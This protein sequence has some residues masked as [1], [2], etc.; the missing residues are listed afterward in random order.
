MNLQN[1]KCRQLNSFKNLTLI[2]I[3]LFVALLIT[4]SFCNL[5]ERSKAKRLIVITVASDVNNEGF[6]RFNRSIQHFGHELVVLGSNEEWRGGDLRTNSGGGQK[7]NYFY[8]ALAT[9]K[10]ES[11]LAILF[12]DSYDL[13]INANSSKI[14]ETYESKFV[15]AN[16][17]FSAEAT[18]WPD[19]NLARQFPI[20]LLGGKKYLNSGAIIGFAPSLWQLV[21]IVIDQNKKG[22]SGSGVPDKEDDQLLYSRV[23]LNETLRETLA[24]YLDHKSELFQS[25]HGSSKEIEL[26]FQDK[27]TDSIH[28]VNKEYR[29]RPL[30]IHGNGP[31]DLFLDIIGDYIGGSWSLK[32]GCVLCKNIEFKDKGQREERSVLLAL[33][34]EDST[35]FIERY[36]ELIETLEYPRNKLNVLV[37]NG[38]EYHEPSVK[39]FVQRNTGKFAS[40]NLL[41]DMDIETHKNKL[42]N[43]SITE[44]IT[45]ETNLTI[46][47]RLQLERRIRILNTTNEQ[48]LNEQDSGDDKDDAKY[49][50][51]ELLARSLSLDYCVKLSLENQ[52]DYYF[53]IDS[54]SRFDN[55]NTLDIL[56]SIAETREFSS[57]ILAPAISRPGKLWS[58]YWR[59]IDDNGYYKRSFD[60]SELVERTRVGV[61]N[62]PLVMNSFLFSS[63]LLKKNQE[64]IQSRNLFCA[65]KDLNNNNVS[66][67]IDE[68]PLRKSLL[69]QPPTTNC[70]F[71]DHIKK[72]DSRYAFLDGDGMF[73]KPTLAF[74][75]YLRNKQ[76][77]QLATNIHFFGHLTNPQF[78]DSTRVHPDFYE[79]ENNRIEWS[80]EYLHE[81]YSAAVDDADPSAPKRSPNTNKAVHYPIYSTTNSTSKIVEQPCPDVYWFPLVSDKFRKQLLDIMNNYGEWSNGANNDSRIEGGYENVPT[82]DIH[83]RQV[84]LHNMWVK[85]LELYVSPMQ[86][87]VYIGY[88][89][90]PQTD[91]AF[92]VRYKPD[93]QAS[94]RPHHDSSTYTLNIALNSP[95]ID[96]EGGGCRFVRYNCSVTDSRP[97]WGLLHPG[98]LTH[99]HEGLTVTKGIRY[100]LVTFI[101]P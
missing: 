7:I 13:I 42:L 49:H 56:L 82:R 100:I 92:V 57:S 25:L 78:F 83:F 46:Q 6:K 73:T 99:F 29:T 38:V 101:D 24:I 4:P 5:Q 40:L 19:T 71:H 70:L 50:L 65:N 94:L 59:S 30:I 23:F 43:E 9:Y 81:N 90:K 21:G 8:K 60:Y 84:G 67:K 96:Y 35:P 16:I 86:S 45:N 62:V 95:G 76:I 11:Q 12:V 34:I 54:M 48:L 97:G 55:N 26:D 93:E 31:S 72:I 20:P 91:L 14:L 64:D 80:Q 22:T 61:W 77:K 10:Q 68:E 33:F 79:L 1:I 36:F 15:E 58:N 85:F 88:E 53:Y 51:D 75:A 27:E 3:I 32:D 98:R 87:K 41:T 37:H 47:N 89:G 69:A 63:E 44:L 74:A 66:E 39:E 28:V 52:C 2:S 18:C 17:V